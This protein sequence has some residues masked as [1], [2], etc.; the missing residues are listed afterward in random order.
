MPRALQTSV[1]HIS[2][3]ES[4][5]RVVQCAGSF[6]MQINASSSSTHPPNEEP[7]RDASSK[8]VALNPGSAGAAGPA[9]GA[10]REGKRVDGIAVTGSGL[11]KGE[12]AFK[13]SK[14]SRRKSGS[15]LE[16][17]AWIYGV[18]ADTALVAGP[19]SQPGRDDNSVPG[20]LFVTGTSVNCKGHSE[21]R[22]GAPRSRATSAAPHPGPNALGDAPALLAAPSAQ[23]RAGWAACGLLGL[24]VC[25][26]PFLAGDTAA[27]PCQPVIV[28]LQ[29]GSM[30]GAHQRTQVPTAALLRV[31]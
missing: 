5:V 2:D 9:K 24:A 3:T 16:Q 29:A 31:K 6:Q 7:G 28:L 8:Q 15:A 30:D 26:W 27:T 25:A 23:A 21:F 20:V 12:A 11:C 18:H 4:E 13:F 22:F 14:V 19:R 17:E 1:R 10:Q